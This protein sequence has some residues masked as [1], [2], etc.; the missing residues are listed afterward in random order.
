VLRK[1]DLLWSEYSNGDFGFSVQCS[2]WV[3]FGG[4][5][6]IY[7]R[8]HITTEDKIALGNTEAQLAHQPCQFF[9]A[10]G[11]AQY[12]LMDM[13]GKMAKEIFRRKIEVVEVIM[14][15][16]IMTPIAAMLSGYE[17]VA[18]LSGGVFCHFSV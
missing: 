8:D 5:A 16:K 9:L 10:N 17:F 14:I 3:E 13:P 11:I 1:I 18:L 12:Q 6:R 7:M 2:L 15:D 4:E